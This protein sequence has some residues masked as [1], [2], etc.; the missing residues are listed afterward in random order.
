MTIRVWLRVAMILIFDVGIVLVAI[1][2]AV[3]GSRDAGRIGIG[4][5]LL[6]L[7]FGFI[8]L[9][10]LAVQFVPASARDVGNIISRGK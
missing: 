4:L 2:D 7:W 5:T 8:D 10:V 3:L 1:G 9:A 6:A